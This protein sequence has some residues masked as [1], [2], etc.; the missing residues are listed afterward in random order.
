MT[1][2]TPT[3]ES[4]KKSKKEKRKP[5]IKIKIKTKINKHEI[6]IHVINII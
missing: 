4:N 1:Q 5:I 2:C 3:Q 6:S